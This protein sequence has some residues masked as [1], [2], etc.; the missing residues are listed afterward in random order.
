MKSYA[1]NIKGSVGGTG[2][3]EEKSIPDYVKDE[4]ER[5]DAKCKQLEE[6]NK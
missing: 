2:S 3:P 4:I 5:K 6:D 1:S